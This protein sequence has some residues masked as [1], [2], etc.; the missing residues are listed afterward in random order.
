MEVKVGG[1]VTFVRLVQFWN[2]LSAML[3]TPSPMTTSLIWALLS[4]QVILPMGPSPLMVNLPVSGSQ[5]VSS[6]DASSRGI[7][8]ASACS[9]S[10]SGAI[11]STTAVSSTAAASGFS[12]AKAVVGTYCS[13]MT[14]ARAKLSSFL[15]FSFMFFPP[16]SQPGY[17]FC[18]PYLYIIQ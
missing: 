5:I 6:L 13:T 17:M 4:F 1:R 18:I 9:T 16:F 7:A 3:V 11:S 15:M 2:A 8:S 10:I 14:S 12:A